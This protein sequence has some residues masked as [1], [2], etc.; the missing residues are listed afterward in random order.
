[1]IRCQSE[2]DQDLARAT[3]ANVLRDTLADEAALQQQANEER[4]RVYELFVAHQPNGANR[5]AVGADLSC[6]LPIMH[7]NKIPRVT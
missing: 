3:I 7:F 1:M 5:S 4:S 6:Q 2:L